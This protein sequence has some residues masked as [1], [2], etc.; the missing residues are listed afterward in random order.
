MDLEN[1]KWSKSDK[2]RQI[3]DITYMRNLKIV[4]MN[5]Y[6]K[7]KETYIE[8]KHGSQNGGEGITRIMRLTDSNYY[9]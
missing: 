2:E 6:T 9:T 7:Q 8:N 5:L 3:Y 1:T 4:Q